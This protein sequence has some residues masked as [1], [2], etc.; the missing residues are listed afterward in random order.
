MMSCKKQNPSVAV[1]LA[2]CCNELSSSFPVSFVFSCY[3]KEG[4]EV[5]IRNCFTCLIF[6]YADIQPDCL[7]ASIVNSPIK[8]YLTKDR[9]DTI[10][11]GFSS[12]QKNKN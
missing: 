12:A 4:N 3:C 7:E 5:S 6:V 11:I 9:K 10:G 1:L 2:K 8:L